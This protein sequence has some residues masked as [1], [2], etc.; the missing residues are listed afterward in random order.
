MKIKNMFIWNIKKL[1]KSFIW[2]DNMDKNIILSKLDKV[3]KTKKQSYFKLL[4]STTQKKF[5]Y[6]DK[7][8]ATIK[9]LIRKEK[10]KFIS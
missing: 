8:N 4:K 10:K 1:K 6:F 5:F 7:N 9:N 3:F 2:E